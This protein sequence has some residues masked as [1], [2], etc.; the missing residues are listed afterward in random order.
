MRIKELDSL[1]QDK[2]SLF[3]T[4]LLSVIY[5]LPIM[6]ADYDYLDDF[7]R[8]LFGYGWQHD[9][10]FIATLLGKLWS[11]NSAVFSIYPFSLLLSAIVLGFTGYLLVSILKIEENKLVKWSS[12][13]IITAPGFLGNLVFKYDCLPMSLSLFVVVFPF[14]FYQHRLKF[15]IASVIGVF[16]S[17]GLYQSSSTVFFIIGS[18]F[19]IQEI[20]GNNWKGF[21]YNFIIIITSFVA[22]FICYL[23]VLK[24]WN[25]QISSRASFI[26][27]EANFTEL[28]AK[29]NERFFDMVSLMLRSGNYEYYVV[30][31]LI[32][33]LLGFG[34]FIYSGKNKLKN[35]LVLPLILIIIIT[36]FWLIS[37]VN[38]LLVNSY[39]DLRTFCGLGFFLILCVYFHKYLKGTIKKVSRVSIA[40]LV[41]FSFVLIAQ[42][43]K[44]LTTQTQFQN[45]FITEIKPYTGNKNIKNIGIIG[46]LTVAPK[47]YFSYSQFPLFAN[48]LQSPI[49]QFSSWNKEVMN[50]NG[51]FN[52]INIITSNDLKCKG[53]LIKDSKFYNIRML[54]SDT[55]ILDFNRSK[56]KF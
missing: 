50:I 41:F 26:I 25:L 2:K 45:D 14:I 21:F 27:T 55:L 18:I 37:G 47:N 54:N 24:L 5:V 17:F 11:L 1:L 12:M 4:L 52:E 43:G 51:A 10:R 40:I 44:V 30:L 33:T 6:T 15:I 48:L 22:A 36:S 9:G 49:G 34:Y 7:G 32:F 3:I 53:T 23:I 39:W 42:F 19:L 13:L 56:C 29:N 38:I 20:I 46:T 31:L 16:L 8:N 35:L 28:L